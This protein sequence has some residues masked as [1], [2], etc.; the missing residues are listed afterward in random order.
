MQSYRTFATSRIALLGLIFIV[1]LSLV[2]IFAPILAPYDPTKLVDTR[3][4]PPSREYL[5]GTDHLGRDVFS[6]IVYGARVSL[7]AGFGAQFLSLA[8]GMPLGL[9][10][11]FFGGRVDHLIMRIVDVFMSFPYILLA[12]L[13]ASILGP[14]LRNVI[15]AL[16]ITGWTS[17]C[18]IA[19]VQALSVREAAFVES[20]RAIGASDVRIIARHILPNSL[21]PITVVATLGIASAITGEAALSFL[22]MGIKPPEPSWGGMLSEAKLYLYAS[23]TLGVFPG[24]AI[25]MAVLGFNLVGDGLRDALDPRLR[26]R[27]LG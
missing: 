15:L 20:C 16:G 21:A 4:L 17:M 19:R 9:I 23:V 11:G 10:A 7:I 2:G 3:L 14:G 24:I 22:G 13:L 18:R 25:M 26:R 27:A 6:R 1:F 8:I 12:L 5:F